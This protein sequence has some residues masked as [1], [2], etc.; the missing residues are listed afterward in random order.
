MSE[1]LPHIQFRV[2]S[3][4]FQALRKDARE[5]K[6]SPALV[7]Q[8]IV[9]AFYEEDRPAKRAPKVAYRKTAEVAKVVPKGSRRNDKAKAD[10]LVAAVLAG[11][12]VKGG[13]RD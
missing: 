11:K 7:A 5:R 1:R 12:R 6:V 8:E 4:T 13:V 2:P 3:S 10:E 9:V